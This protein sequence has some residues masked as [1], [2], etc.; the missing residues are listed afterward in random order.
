MWFVTALSVRLAGRSG[1]LSSS[2]V[3]IITQ[4]TAGVPDDPESDDRL[5]GA[6][7]V[8][9]ATGDG[10]ADVLVGAPGEDIG[11]RVDAGSVTAHD[12]DLAPSPV[13]PATVPR[14]WTVSVLRGRKLSKI[15][16]KLTGWG[17]FGRAGP[18]AGRRGRR[19]S[20]PFRCAGR[21]GD[22]GAPGSWRSTRVAAS[23]VDGRGGV[24]M[25][26]SLS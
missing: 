20:G 24:L 12:H 13:A 11:S 17:A 2:A 25:L 10:K 22:D 19:S 14:S 21:V 4:R 3:Q 5:G 26:I 8:G 23:Q 9:D 15:S 16:T 1:G 18:R 7:S 6:L